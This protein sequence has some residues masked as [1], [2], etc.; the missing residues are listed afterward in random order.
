MHLVFRCRGVLTVAHGW[1]M[2][3]NIDGL[4][5]LKVEAHLLKCLSGGKVGPPSKWKET[6]QIRTLQTFKTA[7]ATSAKLL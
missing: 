6:Q 4:C 7:T 3:H 2:V 1:D 5:Q